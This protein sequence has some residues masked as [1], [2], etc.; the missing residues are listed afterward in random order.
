ME[1]HVV[2]RPRLPGVPSQHFRAEA[3]AEQQFAAD[4]IRQR[5]ARV[6]V[7]D[8]VAAGLKLLPYHR[9]FML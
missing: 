7:D 6:T 4:A 1:R 3:R 8:R 5:L 2:C 9:L